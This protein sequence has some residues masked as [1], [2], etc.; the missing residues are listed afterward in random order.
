VVS[1]TDP[2]GRILGSHNKAVKY[3]MAIAISLFIMVEMCLC[4]TCRASCIWSARVYLA[5]ILHKSH[6]EAHE[7]SRKNVHAYVDFLPDLTL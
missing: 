1:V 4:C 5:P 3:R 2:Y 6:L 7:L